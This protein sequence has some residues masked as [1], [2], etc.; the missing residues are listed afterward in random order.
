[1]PISAAGAA[2]MKEFTRAQ[3][4]ELLDRAR[5]VIERSQDVRQ[6]LADVLAHVRGND[7]LKAFPYNSRSNAPGRDHSE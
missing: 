6:Q 3:A 7:A 1:M 4:R 5:E 2:E